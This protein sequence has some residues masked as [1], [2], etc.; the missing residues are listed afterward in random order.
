MVMHRKDLDPY[1]GKTLNNRYLIRDLIGR[2]GMGRVYMAEDAAK[3]GLPVA[4]K[5]LSLSLAT[6]HMSQRFAR[7]IFI[8]AQLGRKSNHIVRV[9]SY[10]VNEDKIPYYVM[11]CLQGQV[12]KRMLINQPLSI[13]QFL[14]Y[15]QQ[16][17]LGLQCAHQG[18]SLKGEIY[19]VIHRDIKPENIFIHQDSRQKES[20]KILDFGIAKFLTE[21]AGM[22]LTSAFIGS[23]PYCSPEQLEGRKLLDIRTDIYSLGI[24]MFEM[25]TGENPLYTSANSF[26]N[27]YQAHLHQAPRTIADANPQLQVPQELQNLI[28]RCLAKKASDRPQ[29]IDEIFKTLQLVEREVNIGSSYSRKQSPTLQLVP[30]TSLSEE[31]CWQKSWPR[32]KPIAPIVFPHLLVTNQG[33]VASLWVMLP[34]SE[35]EKCLQQVSETEFL[36]NFSVYPVIMW[37]AVLYNTG[38]CPARWLSYYLDIQ[39]VK[40]QQIV[41]SLVEAGYYHL[42]FFAIEEPSHCAHVMTVTLSSSQ[43]QQLTD[44]LELSQNFRSLDAFDESKKLLKSKYEKLK[45]QILKKIIAKQTSEETT[46]K[47][48][49]SHLVEKVFNFFSRSEKS[50]N[51]PRCQS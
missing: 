42:L 32:N 12:L 7:E 28:M 8:G 10:G 34:Q 48:W 18:I 17:C 40:V 31:I 20:V 15:T 37:I 51:Q 46:V 36:I 6:Q 29:N 3:G 13:A 14:N 44:W 5:V 50:S 9:L 22:T 45:P 41:V 38:V 11:E 19:P 24:V 21:R 25:L 23:L 33:N 2:G 39:D 43:R 47:S 49:L 35:I 30:I 16:I 4:V 26:S 1:I 27:W